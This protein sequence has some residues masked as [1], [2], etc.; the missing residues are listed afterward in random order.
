M[1]QSD[2]WFL[3]P[4]KG[5]S[6]NSQL[7]AEK[8]IPHQD[9]SQVVPVHSN[10]RHFTDLAFSE[11]FALSYLPNKGLVLLC[12]KWWP[13]GAC[14]YWALEMQ[15]VRIVSAVGVTHTLDFKNVA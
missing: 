5:G 7:G 11:A 1:G 14:G 4:E 13:R 8:S 2:C 3:L 12:P 9:D 6:D 15:L 10:S